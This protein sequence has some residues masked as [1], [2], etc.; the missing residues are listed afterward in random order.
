[1]PLLIL[2]RVS[3]K[4]VIFAETTDPPQDLVKGRVFYDQQNRPNIK[5][6]WK[7]PN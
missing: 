5:V 6:V 1:M 2:A 7:P 4:L 3:L